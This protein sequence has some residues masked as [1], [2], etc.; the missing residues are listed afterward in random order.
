MRLHTLSVLSSVMLLI[1][2]SPAELTTLINT[3]DAPVT[4]Q[5]HHDGENDPRFATQV[6]DVPAHSSTQ[7]PNFWN[8]RVDTIGPDGSVLFHQENI[9]PEV[10]TRDYASSDRVLFTTRIKTCYAIE[11]DGIYLVPVKYW[12]SIDSHLD[13]IRKRP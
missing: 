3:T 11:K 8:A 5:I 10:L 1:G 4:L 2:C 7:G 13:E 12:D 6:I 9:C